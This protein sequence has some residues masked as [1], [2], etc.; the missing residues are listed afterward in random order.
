M[1]D[2]RHITRIDDDDAHTHG[3]RVRFQ[4]RGDL[5]T[6]LF[7]DGKHKGKE[8]ALAA[9]RKWRDDNH[10]PA[11]P[12]PANENKGRIYLATIGGK[13]LWRVILRIADVP[14]TK[15]FS[16]ARF[17][18]TGAQRRAAEWLY[19]HQEGIPS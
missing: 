16:V 4:R 14:K 18:N 17:G 13:K 10:R 8:R 1:N 5:Q 19:N 3:W 11:A 6:K 12:K 7:S 9:A 15:S 2:L